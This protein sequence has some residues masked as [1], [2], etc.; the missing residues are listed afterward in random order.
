MSR[1]N[2]LSLAQGYMHESLVEDDI[3]YCSKDL[4]GSVSSYYPTVISSNPHWVSLTFF[5]F[6]SCKIF[7]SKSIFS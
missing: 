1:F 6:T 3:L 4:D 2:K 5:V 7:I